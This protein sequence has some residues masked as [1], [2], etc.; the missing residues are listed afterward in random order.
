LFTLGINV[1]IGLIR[2]LRIQI[3]KEQAGDGNNFGRSRYHPKSAYL[4]G[5]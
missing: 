4:L 3:L 5:D 2:E 1:K